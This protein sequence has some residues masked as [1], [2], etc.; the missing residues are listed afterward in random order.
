MALKKIELTMQEIWAATRPVVQR[1]RKKYRRVPK[2]KGKS[3]EPD[4]TQP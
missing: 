4:S 3:N 1:N 2:H